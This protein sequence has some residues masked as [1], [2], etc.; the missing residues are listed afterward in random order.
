MRVGILLICG[1][2]VHDHIFSLRGEV[3]V[4]RTTLAPLLFIEVAV[5]SQEREWSYI[6]VRGGRFSK[7]LRFDIG[8]VPTVCYCLFFLLF[9][10]ILKGTFIQMR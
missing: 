7:I 3:R 5:P 6:C 2:H 4:H 9:F 1:K 8:I 10:V